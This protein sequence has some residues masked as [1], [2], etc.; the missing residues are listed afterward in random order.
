MNFDT[1]V[2]MGFGGQKIES[3]YLGCDLEFY[4]KYWNNATSKS[5]AQVSKIYNRMVILQ[6]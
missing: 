2:S 6:A 4:S 1:F 3:D 5:M